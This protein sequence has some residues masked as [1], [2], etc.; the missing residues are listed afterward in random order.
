M[1]SVV[2]TVSLRRI[3]ELVEERTNG[4]KVPELIVLQAAAEEDAAN[5]RA[6]VV[7]K[8]TPDS[9]YTC[10]VTPVVGTHAGPGTVGI[11]FYTE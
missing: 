9:V 8:V 2:Y 11:A 1:R 4:L 5:L 6:E 10:T 7:A 3:I